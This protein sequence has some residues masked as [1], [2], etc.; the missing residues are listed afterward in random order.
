MDCSL[1]G[2]SLHGIFQAIVLEWIAISYA[3]LSDS[4]PLCIV[5][6]LLTTPA[7][8]FLSLSCS[9]HQPPH[10]SPLWNVPHPLTTVC[11]SWV[12]GTRSTDAFTH[13]IC[14]LPHCLL[15]SHTHTSQFWFSSTPLNNSA[16]RKPRQLKYNSGIIPGIHR[17]LQG[18]PDPW[19]ILHLNKHPQKYPR[20]YDSE[21]VKRRKVKEGQR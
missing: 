13:H 15:L 7:S 20:Y 5:S 14:F 21:N 18:W 12:H 8:C 17:L 10:L 4:N 1:P 6:P 19:H 9:S 3:F 16:L 2:S 11:P